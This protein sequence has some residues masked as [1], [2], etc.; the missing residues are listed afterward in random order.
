MKPATADYHYRVLCLRIVPV[1]GAPVRLTHHPRDLI[2]SNSAEYKTHYGYELTSYVSDSSMSPASIDLKGIADITGISMDEIESGY[3]DSARAY[4]FATTWN[5]PIEDEEP[6][7]ASILGRTTIEDDRYRIEEMALI[8]ALNQSVG[9]TYAPGCDKQFG[10]QEFAGCKVAL[11][12]LT[13]TGTITHTTSRTIIRDDTRTEIA[14]YFGVGSIRFTTG[15]NAGLSGKEIKR[16]E[17]DGTIEIFEAFHYPISVGDEYEM[18]PGCR[19][20]LQDCRDKWG[21]VPNFGGFPHVP[22]SSSYQQI[23]T[24]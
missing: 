20:R 6:I 16:Y 2:M 1:S 4:L 7:A 22:V 8:D 14:D 24:K 19:K 15:P 23:G 21:N 12:P 13:V 10:G 5:N 9:Q 18:I 11:G 17:A 3:F